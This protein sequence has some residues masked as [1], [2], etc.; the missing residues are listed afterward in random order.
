MIDNTYKDMRS[1]L[2]DA[3]KLLTESGLSIESLST[4]IIAVAIFK[5]RRSIIGHWDK[6]RI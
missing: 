2:K 4:S 5:E 1:A 3:G 6:E